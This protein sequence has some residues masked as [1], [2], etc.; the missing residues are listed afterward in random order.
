VI[1]QIGPDPRIRRLVNRCHRRLSRAGGRRDGPCQKF[2]LCTVP[3][4]ADPDVWRGHHATPE[5]VRK[6]TCTSLTGS[7]SSRTIRESNC[8]GCQEVRA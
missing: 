1:A 3:L 4:R 7:I 2:T 5:P 6:T 8:L